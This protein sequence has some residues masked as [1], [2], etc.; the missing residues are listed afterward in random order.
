MGVANTHHTHTHANSLTHTH[1]HT[2]HTHTTHTQLSLSPHCRAWVNPCTHGRAHTDTHRHTCTHTHIHKARAAPRH[3]VSHL[4][5]SVPY[6]SLM[7]WHVHP[8]TMQLHPFWH[9][10]AVTWAARDGGSTVYLRWCGAV[11]C[12][13]RLIGWLAGS[14]RVRPYG[15]T[16]Y[17]LGLLCVAMCLLNLV[18]HVFVCYGGSWA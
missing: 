10:E 6:Q 5:A 1:K 11:R 3:Q 2:T 4:P 17:V 8:N 14:P 18:A 15:R 9:W 13:A 7:P 16:T 12:A